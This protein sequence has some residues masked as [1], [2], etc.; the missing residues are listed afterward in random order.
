MKDNFITRLVSKAIDDT[1]NQVHYSHMHP[2]VTPPI[3][4][5]QWREKW[6]H[7]NLALPLPK[8]EILKA[9]FVLLNSSNKSTSGIEVSLYNKKQKAP[10]QLFRHNIVDDVTIIL[11]E[12]QN[13]IKISGFKRN[14]NFLMYPCYL[15]DLAEEEQPTQQEIQR[16]ALK[17]YRTIKDFFA[18]VKSAKMPVGWYQLK[19]TEFVTYQ[20]NNW[21][22]IDNR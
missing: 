1:Y 17:G 16:K 11:D 20:A 5:T 13:R 9:D 15:Q 18:S 7:E 12:A 8:T 4:H 2:D 6:I 3:E 10:A 14:Y 19:H 21:V 22:L